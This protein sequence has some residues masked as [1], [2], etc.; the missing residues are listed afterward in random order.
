VLFAWKEIGLQMVKTNT[1]GWLKLVEGYPWFTG[2]GHFPI[3]AY[4]EYMP[5]PR[6]GKRPYTEMDVSLFADNDPFG[7]HVT[8]VEEEY[9]LQRGITDLLSQIEDQVVELGQ[10]KPAFRIAGHER[11]NLM[12]NPYWPPELAAQAGN[13]PH[14]RYVIFLSAAL[15]RTQDDKGRTRWTFFG[16][17]EQ[18]PE[19]AFWKSF[20]SSPDQERP[21]S[22]SLSPLLQILSEV[23]GE[24]CDAPGGLFDIGFR[25][26]PTETNPRFPYWHESNLPTWTQPLRINT[27]DIPD[28]MRYLLTF[29]PFSQLPEVVRKRYLSGQLVLMPFP[30][31]LVFWQERGTCWH[32]SPAIRL[33]L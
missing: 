1:A 29:R 15:S 8:E 26:L 5:P 17:S 10:G 25:I 9:E 32:Q 13:L 7:W 4:S 22:E 14:E 12:N 18:G 6:L 24:K 30:G 21:L 20:Y 16:S 27:D 28:D 31:S 23:Y 2:E 11:R 19:H 3:R 33:V